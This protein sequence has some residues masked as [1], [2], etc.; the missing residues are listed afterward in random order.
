ME[1]GCSRLGF[2]IRTMELAVVLEYVMQMS[3][4]SLHP[5][6][7]AGLLSHKCPSFLLLRRLVMLKVGED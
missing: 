6:K 2:E 5:L 1:L 3:N 7:R 4:Y